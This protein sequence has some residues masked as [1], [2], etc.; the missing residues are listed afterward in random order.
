MMLST[1]AQPQTIRLPPPHRVIAFCE[2][3][4]SVRGCAR[5]SGQHVFTFHHGHSARLS[6]AV[7]GP[8]LTAVSPFNFISKQLC[9]RDMRT[10]GPRTQPAHLARA[11][12]PRIWPVHLARTSGPYI[13]PA[14][15]GILTLKM[16]SPCPAPRR[17][18]HPTDISLHNP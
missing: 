18:T 8:A 10:G 5:G 9:A 14:H 7:P 17:S 2:W 12:G 11:S 6:V 13:W 15:L 4:A 1:V 3:K 16:R